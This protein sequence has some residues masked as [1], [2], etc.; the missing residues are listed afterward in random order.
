MAARNLTEREKNLVIG[1]KDHFKMNDATPAEIRKVCI[2]I[3]SE[4]K[5]GI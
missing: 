3:I 5:N 2:S 4:N 1:V